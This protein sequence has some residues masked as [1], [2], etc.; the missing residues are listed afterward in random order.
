MPQIISIA[1]TKQS[2]IALALLLLTG[3]DGGFFMVARVVD[4]E[5]RAIQGVNVHASSK[6]SSN[7]FDSVSDKNGC[8]SLGSLIAPGNFEFSVTAQAIGYK[9]LNFLVPTLEQNRFQLVLAK[10]PQTFNSQA[11]AVDETQLR[12]HCGGI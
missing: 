2:I 3:C 12:R 6:K 5:G 7:V 11:Q 4:S 9:P 1:H 10:Q 8:L